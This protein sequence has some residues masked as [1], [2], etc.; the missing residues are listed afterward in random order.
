MSLFFFVSF[1]VGRGAH[2]WAV[3]HG[4]PPCPSEKMATSEF[5]CTDSE[6][7]ASSKK[8]NFCNCKT[9]SKQM[10]WNRWIWWRF[11]HTEFSLSA[12]KRNK[13]KMELAEK[14]DTGHNQTKKRR[15]ST[16]NV[17][18]MLSF[19]IRCHQVY[20]IP[21]VRMEPSL[22]TIMCII[23]AKQNALHWQLMIQ[24]C[25]PLNFMT[26]GLQENNRNRIS[27]VPSNYQWAPM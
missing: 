22:T 12:Y 16:E 8:C 19:W 4:I 26:I 5:C 13:R 1:L 7:Y 15:Q 10:L 14:L 24:S 17:S 6:I 11:F 21:W 2:D 23:C 25:F 20:D 3:S 9:E 18:S 27:K